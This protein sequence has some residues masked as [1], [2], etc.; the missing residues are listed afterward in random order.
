MHDRRPGQWRN[1]VPIWLPAK[2]LSRRLTVGERG[3]P[4]RIRS[5]LLRLVAIH[6][7]RRHPVNRAGSADGD[8]RSWLA[9]S[10]HRT[11]CVRH[12]GAPREREP[13]YA[14]VTM[15][16]VRVWVTNVTCHC[17]RAPSQPGSLPFVTHPTR[18]RSSRDRTHR[19]GRDPAARPAAL[20]NAQG[21]HLVLP[22]PER[23]GCGAVYAA[24]TTSSGM[25]RHTYHRR[26]RAAASAC[27]GSPLGTS[28]DAGPRHRAVACRM[29]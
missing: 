23:S 29:R 3:L 21:A 25:I 24:P 20:S 28:T 7:H 8:R 5:S 4:H 11:D 1:S 9:S 17:L 14:T 19:P 15:D 26:D 10:H 12:H 6:L 16:R 22:T 18:H 27:N 2:P 13:E